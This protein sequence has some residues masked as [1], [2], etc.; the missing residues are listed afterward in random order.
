M[1]SIQLSIPEPCHE[2]W[3][4]MAANEQGR[5]CASCCKTVVDFSAMSD[6]QMAEFFKKTSG[7]VCGHFQPDQL[8]R[9]LL[10]PKKR[11]PWVKYFFQFTLP[12]FLVA[13]KASAQGKV[14]VTRHA[15][16]FTRSVK[17][18]KEEAGPNE[19]WTNQVS[20][21]ILDNRGNP[22]KDASVL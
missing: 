20:G 21:K 18:A 6:R 16:E 9:D 8:D 22:V 1:K 19:A 4:K 7:P 11:I 17:P 13:T 14:A 2:H 5:F 10:I 12:A 15:V 3:N